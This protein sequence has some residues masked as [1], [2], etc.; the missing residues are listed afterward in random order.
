MAKPE[1][2]ALVE[3]IGIVSLVPSGFV[4]LTWKP[5]HLSPPA[6]PAVA[7]YLSSQATIS[8]YSPTP[9]VCGEVVTYAYVGMFHGGE[10]AA[11]KGIA[12]AK[13]P[14]AI[15]MM[16]KIESTLLFSIFIFASPFFGVGC[17]MDRFHI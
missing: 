6:P 8:V 10:C 7:G 4:M 15:K 13:A 14:V 11:A 2:I 3:G 17:P 12:V 16:A 5:R 1:A 9:T